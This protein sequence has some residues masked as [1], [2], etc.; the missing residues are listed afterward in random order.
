MRD[1]G[2]EPQMVEE[3]LLWQVNSQMPEITIERIR[4]TVELVYFDREY[5]QNSGEPL[6]QQVSNRCLS[7]KGPY[8]HPLP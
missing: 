2:V 7:G 8:G 5:S 1:N 4:E 3:E 6:I